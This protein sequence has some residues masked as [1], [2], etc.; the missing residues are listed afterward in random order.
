MKIVVNHLTRMQPGYICVAGI[1]LDTNR[2]VRPV[3]EGSMLTS[4]MLALHGG[5]FEIG[6]LLDL[7]KVEYVGRAPEI[8]DYHFD[9]RKIIRMGKVSPGPFWKLLKKVARPTFSQIFGPSLKSYGHGAVVKLGAGE[10]SLGCLGLDNKPE[11]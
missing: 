3:I 2:H 4:R 9:P 5:F 11:F 6:H 10:A 8:E 7:G 1:D